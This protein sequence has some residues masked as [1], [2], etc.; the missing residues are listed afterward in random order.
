MFGNK[1]TVD[2]IFMEI[3]NKGEYQISDLEREQLIDNMK[4]EVAH[5]IVEM[6]VNSNDLRPFPLNAILKA[7]TECKIKVSEKRKA[8]S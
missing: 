7:M 5:L 8:K 4:K 3:L 2:E 6:S 1:L